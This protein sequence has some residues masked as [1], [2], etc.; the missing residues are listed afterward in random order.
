M[1]IRTLDDLINVLQEQR[2]IVGGNIP[3]KMY[4]SY[5]GGYMAGGDICD[6][7]I[8]ETDEFSY[9]ELTNDLG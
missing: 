3:V 6:V 1:E 5:D 2:N 7:S 9:V 4:A 8:V